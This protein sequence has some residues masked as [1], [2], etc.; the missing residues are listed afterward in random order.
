[1]LIWAKLRYIIAGIRGTAGINTQPRWY[2][3]HS[4]KPFLLTIKKS[5]YVPF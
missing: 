1:V 4:S 3:D 2:I 5:V